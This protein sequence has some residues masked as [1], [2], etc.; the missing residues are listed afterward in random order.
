M[1]SDRK[2]RKN[3]QKIGQNERQ[4]IRQKFGENNKLVFR[5]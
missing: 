1:K 4:E 2:W 3:A 5:L